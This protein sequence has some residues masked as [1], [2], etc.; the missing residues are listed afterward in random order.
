MEAVCCRRGK[1]PPRGRRLRL[2][3]KFGCEARRGFGKVS[4][5]NS[6]G[7]SSEFGQ[8]GSRNTLKHT[9]DRK[10]SEIPETQN[11]VQN[12]RKEILCLAAAKECVSF[13]FHFDC[14]NTALK[15]KD[16]VMQRYH[17]LKKDIYSAGETIGRTVQSRIPPATSRNRC[18]SKCSSVPANDS[19]SI[20]GPHT[21]LA[22]LSA[23][24]WPS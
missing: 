9:D 15:V 2:S 3:C 6:C 19:M 10:E 13:L 21:D 7:S 24:Y 8:V 23:F 5:I 14:N 12:T 11:N 20:V 22:I 17:L 1:F 4:T 16:N 18:P